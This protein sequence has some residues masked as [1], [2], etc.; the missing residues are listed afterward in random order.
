[1]GVVVV[2]LLSLKIVDKVRHLNEK[3]K[4]RKYNYMTVTQCKYTS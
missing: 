4:D 1:M 3:I 2:V